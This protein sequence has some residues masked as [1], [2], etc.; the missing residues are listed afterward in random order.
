MVAV[1]SA[2]SK[3]YHVSDSRV[4]I[5]EYHDN[6]ILVC[7]ADRPR[8][9]RPFCSNQGSQKGGVP[10]AA[11]RDMSPC[12]LA[13]SLT[14]VVSYTA[15]SRTE[16]LLPSRCVVV[17]Q[18]HGSRIKVSQREMVEAQDILI[19]IRPAIRNTHPSAEYIGVG[20]TNWVESANMHTII[21][22]PD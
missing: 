20:M 5:S 15:R 6:R 14:T 4:A 22:N 3:E 10:T 18:S 21:T 1:V 7:L 8:G 11:D 13:R 17:A 19:L 2:D 12:V 16:T 9:E